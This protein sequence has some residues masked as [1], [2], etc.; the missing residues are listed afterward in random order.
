MQNNESF[1]F[2]PY[3][4]LGDSNIIRMDWDC[5]AMHLHLICIAW[6]ED[7]KGYILNDDTLLKKLLN[8]PDVKDWEERIKPQIIKA[9]KFKKI[10]VQGKE[11]EYI[12][13]PELIKNLSLSSSSSTTNLKTTS[14]KAKNNK[15]IHYGFQLE[16]ILNVN[17]KQTILY[18]KPI[19]ATKEEKNSIWTMGVKILIN[20]GHNEQKARGFLARLI[21]QYGDKNVAGAIA[22]LSINKFD[23]VDIFSY[24]TGILNK[25]QSIK[26]TINNRGKVSI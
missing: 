17:E 24:L 2:S 4:W 11:T 7:N 15:T 9:W 3:K 14:K 6:Q 13:H 21:K 16:K 19:E 5:R 12:Y 1:L 25:D 10:L 8:N 26:K 23:P 18:E 20:N 22:Q